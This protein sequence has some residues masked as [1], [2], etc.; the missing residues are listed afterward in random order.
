MQMKSLTCACAAAAARLMASPPTGAHVIRN[1]T[2]AKIPF[3]FVVA[4]KT[5]PAGD[6]T[7]ELNPNQY[8]VTIRGEHGDGAISFVERTG[9]DPGGALSPRL[10]FKKE[11]GKFVLREVR[12]TK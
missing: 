11:D 3:D 9:A 2:R 8:I 1:G 6:Y 7:F 10:T 4:G 5:L 12:A